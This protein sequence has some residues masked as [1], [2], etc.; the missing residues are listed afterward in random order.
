VDG[1]LLK[2]L[3][4]RRLQYDSKAR[5]QLESKES[6]RGRGLSSPDRADAVIGAAV[7]S[8]PGYG[9]G[10]TAADLPWITFGRPTCGGLFDSEPV[11]FE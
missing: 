3:S 5:I 10:I 1:E 2:Q 6:M 11:N 9:G 8:V 7:M 4:S